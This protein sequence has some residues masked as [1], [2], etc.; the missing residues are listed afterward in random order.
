[1]SRV[2]RR[3]G[4]PKGSPLRAAPAMGTEPDYLLAQAMHQ[5]AGLMVPVTIEHP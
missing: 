3:S 4:L 2:D 1:M 5:P